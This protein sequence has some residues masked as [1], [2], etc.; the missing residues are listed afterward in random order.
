[1]ANWRTESARSFLIRRITRLSVLHAG[2]AD[3]AAALRAPA[4]TLIQ[5]CPDIVCVCVCM[6]TCRRSLSRSRFD[7]D[8]RDT[9]ARHDSLHASVGAPLRR[10]SRLAYFTSK[11]T[12]T[13][14]SQKEPD[15]MP[16]R[17]QARALFFGSTSR[18]NQTH[19]RT[20]PMCNR[21][22]IELMSI[23]ETVSARV[24]VCA[25]LCVLYMHY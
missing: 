4:R 21:N 5:F 6:L 24:C 3:A 7:R 14:T 2:A 9:S 19:T 8:K 22:F 12:Q 11:R 10:P 20:D 13:C 23:R 1:M 25:C 15:E 17:A 16:A 18:R